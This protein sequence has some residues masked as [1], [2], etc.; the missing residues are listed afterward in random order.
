[1]PAAAAPVLE[2][3]ATLTEDIPA[4]QAGTRIVGH[5]GITRLIAPDGPIGGAIASLCSKELKPVR[6]ILFDKN[7]ET[8]WA[9]GWHQDRAIAVQERHDV[10]GYGPWTVKQGILHVQP[11]FA[12]IARMLTVRIHLD[13]V[14]P[15]NAPLK[16]ALGSHRMGLV[17]VGQ[18]G[19]A[20]Q[21]GQ[22]FSCLADRG[23]VWVY[24]T[25]ILHASDAAAPG[26]RRRVLQIDFASDALPPPL[27][28]LGV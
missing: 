28:W 16:V 12:V 17:P 25:P 26:R 14:D 7:D 24:S 5:T 27:Q 2:Q 8:N 22:I 11:P 19:E 4:D 1:M 6:A 3:L 9:L 13:A 10:A 21:A 23:D 15:H 20:V 18:I